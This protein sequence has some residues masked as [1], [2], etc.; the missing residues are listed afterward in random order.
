M[1]NYFRAIS[2]G[3][4]LIL[5]NSASLLSL[6]VEEVALTVD[7][8]V[9]VAIKSNPEI[10][11]AESRYKAAL[12]RPSRLRTLPDPVVSFVS[13]N[14]DGNPVPFTT[15]GEDSQAFVGLMLEQELPYPG[16]L[17]LAGQVA[18]KEA[19]AIG[20]E[21]D[22]VK[23]STISQ[24]KQAYYQ[25]FRTDRSLEI[26]SESMDLLKRFESIVEQRYSVGQAIQQDVLR[27]QVEISILNQRMTTLEQEK[28][29]AIAEINR[30]LNRPIDSPIPKPADIIPSAFSE[31]LEK[32][33]QEYALKAP[34]IR[35]N[36]AM[37]QREKVSLD[38][39]KKQYKPDFMSSVEY[40]NSPNFP[41]MWRIQFGLRI[42]VYYKKKQQ[43]GVVE[44]THNVTRAQ[45]ELRAASQEIG[46]SVKDEYL[47]IESSDKLIRLYQQ[48]IIPQSNL[49]LESGIASYQ[50]GK[51]D[52]LTT[53]S[54]FLTV[55]EYRMNYFEELA[56]HES[57]IARLEQAVGR[58]LTMNAPAGGN[59]E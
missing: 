40:G 33:Q 9:Q 47:K 51:A 31:A 20:A 28:S 8:L 7:Q 21:V 16:K 57:A 17:K 26:L 54:N 55:L 32:L 14:M 29:S 5:T 13:V 37:L 11:A 35:A 10:Q 6:Q 27:A 50:V 15:L 53:I 4:L 36:E 59:N 48:A 22:A 45:K 58:S 24:L 30:L 23:W 19:D 56:K 1:F 43:Y 25:Y 42:P 18:Q 44:A 34:L 46:F 52:F 12:A 38:L 39:A 2:L 3:L 49:A 41:D